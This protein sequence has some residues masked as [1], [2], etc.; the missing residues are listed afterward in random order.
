MHEA[1]LAARNFAKM[2]KITKSDSVRLAIVVEELV[3]NLYDHGGLSPE[4]V[5]QL[6]LSATR[7][8]I[9]VVL[10]DPGKAF[11]PDLRRLDDTTPERGGG[12]GLRLVQAWT[13]STDYQSADGHNRLD[14]LLPRYRV[15]A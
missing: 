9:R 2:A 5:F 15:R 6:E 14:L 7:T 11:D 8:D 3:T 10:I 13:I 4:D 1:I 12:A